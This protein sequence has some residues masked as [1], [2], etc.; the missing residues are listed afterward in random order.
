MKIFQFIILLAFFSNLTIVSQAQEKKFIL[1]APFQYT[2]TKNDNDILQLKKAHDILISPRLMFRINKQWAL[3][4]VASIWISNITQGYPNYASDD[5]SNINL[6]YKEKY[7]TMKYGLNLQRYLY[8]NG[9][10]QLFTEIIGLFGNYKSKI[11]DVPDGIVFTPNSRKYNL[12]EAGLHIGG[13]YQF[14]NALGI[15]ARINQLVSYQEKKQKENDYKSSQFNVINN[16]FNNASIGI[17]Y[18]F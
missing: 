3:G 7:T 10:V 5:G 8:D 15:E 17:A 18:S 4:P 14:T 13:R 16:I 2:T 12:F 1:S 11:F 9:R 6:T